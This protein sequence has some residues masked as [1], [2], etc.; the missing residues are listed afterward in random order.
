M[1][2]KALNCVYKYITFFNLPFV[3]F[4]LNLFNK[5]N[6]YY[7]NKFDLRYSLCLCEQE[8]DFRRKRKKYIYEAIRCM[9]PDIDVQ[10]N[11]VSFFSFLSLYVFYFFFPK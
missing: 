3:N 4:V 6:L 1:Y 9:Y 10:E 7:S 11:Q 2:T 8:N 5:L